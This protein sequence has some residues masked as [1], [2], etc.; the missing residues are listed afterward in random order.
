VVRAGLAIRGITEVSEKLSEI[1][2]DPAEAVGELLLEKGLDH[3]APALS[4][5]PLL[6]IA[7]AAYKSKGAISDYMFTKKVQQFYTAWDRLDG[8][9]RRKI[10][11]K[12]Q[13]K[14]RVFIEKLLFILAQQEDLEKCRLLGVLTT[15]Y[16]QGVIKRADYLD[17]IETISH[18]SLR[19]LLKLRVL[20]DES[21]IFP[22]GKIGERYASQFL[23]RGLIVTE[24]PLPAEQWEGGETFY[25]ATKLGQVLIE[26][27]S[28]AGLKEAK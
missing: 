20:L 23:P 8:P 11:E 9:E 3:A 28:L 5:I 17:L 7:I 2:Q 10:Y 18:L 21:L 13:K 19:D 1:W 4:Q 24:R 6:S 27:I 16:L 14:P 26:Q 12:F 22:E 15:S 25:R